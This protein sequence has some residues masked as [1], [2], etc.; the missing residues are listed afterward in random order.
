[1]A[2]VWSL[3]GVIFVVASLKAYIFFL[4]CAIL[5]DILYKRRNAFRKYIP[6]LSSKKIAE[7]FSAASVRGLDQIPVPDPFVPKVTELAVDMFSMQVFHA[8]SLVQ[9]VNIDSSLSYAHYAS[10][11]AWRKL[12][13]AS[14]ADADLKTS[15]FWGSSFSDSL[16]AHSEINRG[17]AN[18]VPF[19]RPEMINRFAILAKIPETA[20]DI[21]DEAAIDMKD[22]ELTVDTKEEAA[23]EDKEEEEEEDERSPIERNP[24]LGARTSAFALSAHPP[25]IML[26]ES[27]LGVRPD[28]R[29]W[30]AWMRSPSS[31]L[32]RLN[33]LYSAVRRWLLWGCANHIW[34]GVLINGYPD[35]DSTPSFSRPARLTLLLSSVWGPVALASLLT[36]GLSIGCGTS[37]TVY[38]QQYIAAWWFVIPV[39]IVISIL[40]LPVTI[41]MTL[42][43]HT[44][45]L[46]PV[47]SE[48][49]SASTTVVMTPEEGVC[50]LR[51]PSDTQ[52]VHLSLNKVE[53]S[54][55]LPQ[56]TVESLREALDHENDSAQQKQVLS[57]NDKFRALKETIL[58]LP[59][60]VVVGYV[61]VAV[62]A[63]VCGVVIVFAP[64][65]FENQE[66]VALW[67]K[68]SVLALFQ[69]AV[70]EEG[71]R[72]VGSAVLIPLTGFLWDSF[73]FHT[74]QVGVKGAFQ[75]IVDS[76][77]DFRLKF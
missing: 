15:T 65:F 56:S 74:S 36:L 27:H 58:K 54:V 4:I 1:M 7:E 25:K 73:T 71:L 13:G 61:L 76:I 30:P 40:W 45:A 33:A 12:A 64:L 19:M 39:G 49:E 38:S 31:H 24:L 75:V 34:L 50:A 48:C 47:D 2:Y 77:N 29:H 52:C 72:I 66:Y 57:L 46:A 69:H 17:M 32:Y 37:C 18:P 16:E 68:I 6:R 28:E 67:A 43:F 14:R 51:I 10:Y 55:L 70:I 11:A 63:L 20:L 42:I 8:S 9:A 60:M 5:L 62:I 21:A 53:G 41:L 35:R 44:T 3:D 23:K 59:S 22:V 26:S